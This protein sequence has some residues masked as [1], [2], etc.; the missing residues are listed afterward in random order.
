MARSHDSANPSARPR[1]LC[2]MQLPPPVHGA[3]TMNQIVA[4]SEAIAARF[5]RSVIALR[6]ADSVADIGRPSLGK[7]VRAVGVGIRLADHLVRRRPDLVYLTLSRD[8]G[9]FYR[10]CFY[11]ALVKLARRPL[12]FHLHMQPPETTS[13][14]HRWVFTNAHV[15][16]L[17]RA[18]APGAAS[19]SVSVVANGI[20]D[21]ARARTRPEGPPR[22]LFLSHLSVAKGPLLL[23]EALAV[24]ASRGVPFRATLAGADAGCLPQVAARVRE[25]GL[26]ALVDYVGP[27]YDEAKHALFASHDLVVLPSSNE[28]FPL[29]VL[30]AMMWGLPVVATQVGALAEIVADGETGTLVPAGETHAL[31]TA[32]EAYLGDPALRAT[33]G[34]RGRARFVERFTRARFE[35]DL[36]EALSRCLA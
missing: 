4:D 16:V 7:L 19:R 27:A 26:D 9:A 24:L 3:S 11:V 1:L 5:D 28:A 31:A 10:D 17:A 12:V 6:F 35:A 2:V 20:A 22:V 18:L 36:V 29:V 34:A 33:H 8:G 14:L 32:L 23:L 21:H 25:L 15:I 30:E 13:W